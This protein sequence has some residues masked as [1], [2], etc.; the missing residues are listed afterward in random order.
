MHEETDP[1]IGDTDVGI[2]ILEEISPFW[3]PKIQVVMNETQVER[4]A[5]FGSVKLF[6]D[7][8]LEQLTSLP[9]PNRHFLLKRGGVPTV[10]DHFPPELEVDAKEFDF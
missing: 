2:S 6:T 10:L 9:N 3:P 8:P 4:Q 5:V 1:V 7:M